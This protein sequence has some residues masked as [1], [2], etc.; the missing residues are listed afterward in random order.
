[1]DTTKE[2]VL[3]LNKA[4]EIQ[5]LWVLKPGDYF[6]RSV[7]EITTYILQDNEYSCIK[8]GSQTC[9]AMPERTWIGNKIWIPR[10]DQLQG[11]VDIDNWLLGTL[12]DFHKF[13]DLVTRP[14]T[15]MEQLWLAFVMKEKHLKY[16][17]EDNWVEWGKR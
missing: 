4:W 11:M 12:G 8:V 3:M 7:R 16:W 10:Q 1:M 14:F 6:K 17:H 13:C 9:S 2:N 5:N 15:S